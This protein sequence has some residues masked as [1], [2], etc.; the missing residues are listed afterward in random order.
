MT[1]FICVL[2]FSLCVYIIYLLENALVDD[3]DCLRG[4]YVLII[5]QESIS[6]AVSASIFLNNRNGFL[7]K[8]FRKISF[9]LVFRMDQM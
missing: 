9:I 6:I 7:M 2:H 5:N 4:E 8:C 1:Q 3:Q